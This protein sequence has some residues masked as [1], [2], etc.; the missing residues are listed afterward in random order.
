MR[1]VAVFVIECFLASL[2]ECLKRSQGGRKEKK[3]GT[4]AMVFT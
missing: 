2:P 3:K 1:F 4:D